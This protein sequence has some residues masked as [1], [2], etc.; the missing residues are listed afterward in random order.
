MTQN[1]LGAKI[2]I[3][4]R[5]ISYKNKNMKYEIYLAYEGH[6][7]TP[8]EIEAKDMADIYKKVISNIQIIDVRDVEDDHYD[9]G[10]K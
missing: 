8:F 1:K 2:K 4:E 10:E 9:I 6:E 3:V 7:T 5:L